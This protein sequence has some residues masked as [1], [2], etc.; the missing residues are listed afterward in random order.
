MTALARTTDPF[1]VELES[2]RAFL[3]RVS[4]PEEAKRVADMARAAE[5]FA[6]RQKLG[7][8]FVTHAHALVIESLTCMGEFLKV[9]EKNEGGRPLKT[10]SQKEGVFK[11]T[12]ADAGISWKE[13]SDAQALVDIRNQHPEVYEQVRVGKLSVRRARAKTKPRPVVAEPVGAAKS[14]AYTDLDELVRSGR[15][16]A[17]IYADPP[18]RYSNQGTR[19]ATNNHYSTM[20]VEEIAA[21]PVGEL[22][23]EKSHLW[24]WTTN[25]FLFE[26]PRLFAA[27]GFEFR[28]SYVWVKPQ[29]GIGNYLRNSHEFLLLATRGGLVGAARDVRSWGQYD[30]TRHSAKPED[31]R[32]SVVERVSPGPRLELFARRTTPDW[33]VWGNEVEQTLD[34]LE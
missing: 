6:R 28:S 20:T 14:A 22:A 25:G 31:I 30:R 17:T 26:C 4:T 9:A 21:L 3:A 32:E 33:T 29:I 23:A 7:Q 11:S 24:L 19:A 15:K 8:E 18:W 12:L 5:M 34:I 1:E 27:W 10:P 2:T 16:F 13:S